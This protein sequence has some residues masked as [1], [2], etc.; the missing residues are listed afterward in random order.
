MQRKAGGGSQQSHW[1]HLLPHMPGLGQTFSDCLPSPG[2]IACSVRAFAPLLRAAPPH[3]APP[4]CAGLAGVNSLPA[5]A[6]Y[7]E[8]ANVFAKPRG[9]TDFIPFKGPGFA[10]R[11]SSVLPPPLAPP[12]VVEWH[13]FRI[14]DSLH[15]LLATSSRRLARL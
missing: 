8:A 12:C 4:L 7:G 13:L 2:L 6:A 10:V 1:A 11:R 5:L 3:F 14:T 9:N 15:T